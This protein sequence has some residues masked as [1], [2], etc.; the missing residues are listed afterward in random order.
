[1]LASAR[2]SS[3][4][5]PPEIYRRELRAHSFNSQMRINYP[6]CNRKDWWSWGGSNPRPPECHSG[7]LPTELQPHAGKFYQLAASCVYQLL[8]DTDLF[9]LA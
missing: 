6:I 5:C 3:A 2:L 1:M 9:F 8:I 7:T 4:D